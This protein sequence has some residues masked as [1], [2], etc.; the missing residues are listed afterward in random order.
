MSNMLTFNERK[1]I[2]NLSSLI[3]YNNKFHI[4]G[5]NVAEHSFYVA[6]YTMQLCKFLEVSKEIESLAIKKALIHDVHEIELSDIPHNIK[7]ENPSLYAFCTDKEY[8]FNETHF[9]D[10]VK[11]YREI[12]TVSGLLVDVIVNIA[13]ILEVLHYSEFEVLLGNV[14][15]NE[16]MLSATKRIKEELEYFE[17]I[18][19]KEKAEALRKLLMEE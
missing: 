14:M 7:D 1:E 9:P 4:H 8:E 10:I 6:F 13:D 12:D 3:R 15:F 17:R 5:E 18:L 19:D 11:E 2:Q 16:I